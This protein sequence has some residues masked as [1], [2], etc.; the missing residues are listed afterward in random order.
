[1]TTNAD[2]FELIS[3]YENIN[4]ITN[5]LYVKNHSLQSK[6]KQFLINECISSFNH[7]STP[8]KAKISKN[9]FR[10]KSIINKDKNT[11]KCSID[12]NQEEDNKS[13]NSFYISKYDSNRNL[14]NISDNKEKKIENIKKRRHES[15][16]NL[17]EKRKSNINVKFFEIINKNLS[18]T[19][20]K[21]KKELVTVNKKLDMI[22]KNINCANKN[23]NN[24]EEFY[25]DF[26]NNIINKVTDIPEKNN[27]SIDNSPERKIN[28][29]EKNSP[30][31][32]RFI[33]SILS[34]DDLKSKRKKEISK[35]IVENK[36]N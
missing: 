2:S 19:E 1:M 8:L 3:S 24:P 31:H 10:R 5:N 30:A 15:N 22:S 36:I 14:V 16:I 11:K 25:M 35:D 4:K 27:K 18:K 33:D 12:K 26:F 23:I 20:A 29:S 32:K 21:S 9:F 7:D 34:S 17:L 6:T 13:V 28:R